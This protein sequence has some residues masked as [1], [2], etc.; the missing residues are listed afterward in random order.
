MKDLTVLITAAGV[1]FMP[2][3]VYCLKNNGERNIRL[4]GTDMN[5]DSTISQMVDLFYTVPPVSAENYVDE[6]LNI[7]RKENVDILI[8][9]MSQ[10]LP[11]FKK[12]E[13]DFS[14]IGTIVSAAS[15]NVIEVANNKYKFYSFLSQHGLNV[16]Q[17]YPVHSVKEFESA[18]K[19][20]GYP[21]KAICLKMTESSGSRGIRIIDPKKSRADILFYEKPNS[22]FTSMDEL[23]TILKEVGN[24]PEMMAM[25]Y[26]PGKELSV[27]LLAHEGEILYICGRESRVINASI[28][29][30]AVLIEDKEAY[31]ICRKVTK[32]LH[33]D[34]NADFD[35]KYDSTGKPVLMEVNPRIAATMAVFAAGGLNLPYLRIKQLLGEELP[36]VHINYGIKMKRRYLEMFTDKDGN[37]IKVSNMNL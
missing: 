18:A 30:E 8:P 32:I 9:F 29:L 16:P 22:F 11:L 21:K 4:I 36:D 12:R 7:C 28:P 33:L 6:I 3:L 34:G 37:E 25:E 27:D 15:L 31:E 14:S 10:E 13:L 2:G 35:F 5:A 19:K 1:P 23:K 26:L 20:L 24:M 17:F